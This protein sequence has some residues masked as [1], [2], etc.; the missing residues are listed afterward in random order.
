MKKPLLIQRFLLAFAAIGIISSSSVFAQ[1]SGRY[2]EPVFPSFI[3][4]LPVSNVG[5]TVYGSAPDYQG[6]ETTL[7]M[8]VFE[9]ENDTATKRPLIVFAFG[10]SFTAGAKESPDVI[11]LCDYFTQMGYVTASIKYRIGANP[12]DSVNML[13]AVVRGVHDSKAALRYFYKDAATTNTYRIDTNNIFM[14]GVSAGGLIGVHMGYMNDTIGVPN[15]IK[16][17]ITNLTPS[18]NLEG[19]SGNPGYSSKIKGII[20]LSA[21]IGDTAWIGPNDPPMVS[22]HGDDDGTVPYCTDII[23]VSGSDIITVDGSAT[24]KLRTDHI[25]LKNNFYTWVGAGHVP[26]TDPQGLISGVNPY[27]DTTVRFV[28]NFLFEILTGNVCDEGFKKEVPWGTFC[29]NVIKPEAVAEVGESNVWN[30][31][32]NPSSSTITIEHSDLVKGPW[33]V[34]LYNTMGQ[35]VASHKNIGDQRISISKNETGTGLYFVKI[36]GAA[37]E[38]ISGSRVIFE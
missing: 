24:M 20:N 30:I 26:F 13:S 3:S 23:N 28:R 4:F 15:W 27:M 22:L 31:F 2:F 1:C 6:V 25:G 16:D 7:D 14:G 19:E 29:S 32:P 36:F 38:L 8:Y 5:A 12:I 18:G 9:P 35:V 17:I 33:N 37:G 21:C 11:R 10:G 34:E